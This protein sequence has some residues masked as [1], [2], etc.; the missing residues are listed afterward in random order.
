[1]SLFDWVTPGRGESRTSLENPKIP[2]SDPDAWRDT[3]GG[4][5]E[6][7]TGTTITH[8]GS[9]S[10]SPVFC[11]VKKLSGDLA[12]LPWEVYKRMPDDGREVQR[13]HDVHQR[14]NSKFAANPEVSAHKLWRRFYVSCL[15]FEN[16]YLWIDR[17]P[18]G[19]VLGLY[20]LLPDRTAP[21]RRDN[22]ELW[23][24]SEI[25]GRLHAFPY[26]D[27]IHVEGL[28]I[29]NVAGCDL[30]LKARHDIGVALEA[31]KFTSKF[32]K[33][34]LH[35]G[36][37]LQVPPGTTPKARDKVEKAINEKKSGT[38]NA[39]KSLVLRDGF[40][41]F[42]TMVTPENAQMNEVDVAKARDVARFFMLSP[43]DLGIP[44]SKSYNS[45]EQERRNYYDGPLTYH[46]SGTMPELNIKL[47][48]EAERNDG[49]YIDCKINALLWA[50][51]ASVA[52]IASKGVTTGF[53]SNDE[54]R[55]WWNLNPIPDGN[56]KK[57]Y[58]PLNVEEAGAPAQQPDPSQPLRSRLKLLH[59]HA[60]TRVKARLRHQAERASK[61]DDAWRSWQSR[62]VEEN[63]S[64]VAEILDPVSETASVAGLEVPNGEQFLKSIAITR[65]NW[66]E[67]LT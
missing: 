26:E 25:D 55:S 67:I 51:T 54:V 27:V 31:R 1:M 8:D 42:Q 15:L 30:I 62:F 7:E 5:Y 50:D 23:Y 34:G 63:R 18:S 16:G 6:A 48:S 32:F 4:G 47:L 43:S 29:D 52:E 40:R 28:T 22:G 66:Q 12:K 53:L 37:V 41:W 3:L 56:G 57:F 11:A 24:A 58:R 46:L 21:Y 38:D 19:R 10:Y 65:E 39:F 13:Q 2:L 35:A 14:I 61:S 59:D 36:G 60:V 44:D 20:N 64:V 9:L 45:L 17:T 33:N 49:I